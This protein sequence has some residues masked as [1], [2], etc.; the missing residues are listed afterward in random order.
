M[1]L[2]RYS[3]RTILLGVTSC[4]V[5]FLVLGQ[6]VQGRP[7]AIVVSVGVV[8]LAVTLLF[9]AALYLFS[10]AMARLVGVRQLSARTSRGG[11]QSAPD[12]Q[13][14]PTTSHSAEQN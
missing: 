3:L 4:A 11:L 13:V 2:P 6:A 10:S 5:F 9:H 8:S 7:W 1:L 14:P 12:I